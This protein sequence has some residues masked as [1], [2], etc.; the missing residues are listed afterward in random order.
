MNDL[1]RFPTFWVSPQLL[2][3]VTKAANQ[4]NRKLGNLLRRL[5][6][7][8]CRSRD[9]SIEQ[10]DAATGCVRLAVEVQSRQDGREIDGP[11]ERE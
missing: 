2:A 6:V 7:E 11:D 3:A 1:V 5:M 8:E 10:P 9:I 4:D